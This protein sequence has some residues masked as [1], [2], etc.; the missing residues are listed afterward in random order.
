M[1]RAQFERQGILTMVPAATAVA[2]NGAA[3]SMS[4]TIDT[5]CAIPYLYFRPFVLAPQSHFL[6]AIR[7][8]W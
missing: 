4:S 2:H 6:I 7:H 5:A 1:V 8:T 3:R